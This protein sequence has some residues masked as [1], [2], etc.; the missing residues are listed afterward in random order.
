MHTHTEI[1]IGNKKELNLATRNNMDEPQEHYA[2][3]NKSG[4]ENYHLISL[5][6]GI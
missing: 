3:R 4:K 6:C 5:I 2:K 1:L